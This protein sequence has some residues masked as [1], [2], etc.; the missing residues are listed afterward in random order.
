MQNLAL[1][2]SLLA[3]LVLVS[4]APGYRLGLW[5]FRP[6]FGSMQWVVLAAGL[7]ALIGI[8]ALVWSLRAGEAKGRALLAIVIGGAVAAFPMALRKLARSV[9]PIHDI[10]TDLADPPVFA[11]VVPLRG[12]SSNPVV[13]PTPERSEQQRTAYPDLG[14][15]EL[16]G[17]VGEVLDRAE[18]AA[19]RLGWKI[20]AVDKEAGRLEAYDVT[21]WWGFVDDVVVR[22]AA[23]PGGKARVD[24]RSVSRVGVSDLGKNA[25]RIRAFLA[26]LR[27]G[28]P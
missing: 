3:A 4:L 23:G 1:L 14:P 18:A 15:V 24:V 27:K 5:G 28:T 10:S 20:V 6:A 2:V 13:A 11:A 16:A 22:A 19:L 21:A 7:G 8:V 17:S 25:A 26:E 9:P 12:T